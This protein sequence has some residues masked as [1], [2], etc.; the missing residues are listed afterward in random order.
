MAAIPDSPVSPAHTPSKPAGPPGAPAPPP[1]LGPSRRM[2]FLLAVMLAAMWLWKSNMEGAA[3]PPVAYSQL[4]TWIEQGK[5]ESV[6]LKGKVA[7]A[8][9]KGPETLEGRQ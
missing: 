3:Q 8:T 9:L 6:V 5:V 1:A 4:V 7:D 2:F